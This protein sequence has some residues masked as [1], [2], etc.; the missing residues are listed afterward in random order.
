MSKA[1][2]QNKKPVVQVYNTETRRALETLWFR[3]LG[4]MGDTDNDDMIVKVQSVDPSFPTWVIPHAY[5][6]G[7][8]PVKYAAAIRKA[9]ETLPPFDHAEYRR[10]NGKNKDKAPAGDRVERTESG[11]APDPHL[12]PCE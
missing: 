2:H 7:L 4:H 11:R 5:E 9:I 3:F 6:K 12:V 1:Y 8:I 10:Q